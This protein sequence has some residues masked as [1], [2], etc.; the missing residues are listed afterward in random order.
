METDSCIHV[1]KIP[2]AEERFTRGLQGTIAG[3]LLG[4]GI[5]PVPKSIT[6][7]IG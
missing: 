2:M 5:V 1:K 6:W 4:L 3:T 7:G